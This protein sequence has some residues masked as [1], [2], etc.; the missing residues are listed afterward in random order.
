MTPQETFVTRLRRHRQR[1]LLSLD[2]LAAGLCIKRELLEGLEK[3]DLSGWPT[4]LY[5]RAWIRGYAEAVFLDPDDTIDE[6]CRLFPQGDRRAAR[7][8]TA[9][10]GI[11]MSSPAADEPYP[12]EERRRDR[13]Q[14]APPPPQ[15]WHAPVVQGVRAVVSRL[16]TLIPSPNRSIRRTLP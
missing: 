4:G 15:P 16:A 11:V 13:L 1:H 6:F 14:Q 10:A 5:A 8:M 3:N 7:T 12:H 9:F 2:D